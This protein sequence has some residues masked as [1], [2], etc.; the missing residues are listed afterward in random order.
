VS[1]DISD[2]FDDRSRVLQFTDSTSKTLSDFVWGELLT[3]PGSKSQTDSRELFERSSFQNRKDVSFAEVTIPQ[4][5]S[6]H[7]RRMR[8]E[9]QDSASLQRSYRTVPQDSQPPPYYRNDPQDSQPRPYYRN[10]PQDRQPPPYYRNEPRDRQPSH[11][12][13][14]EVQHRDTRVGPGPNGVPGVPPEGYRTLRSGPAPEA[15]KMA[16]S[17][18]GGEYGTMT[19]FDMKGRSYMARVEPHYG[20]TKDN[21]RPHWHKGVTLYEA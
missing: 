19:P 2:M 14:P 20:P 7:Q 16:R 11:N 10:V 9:W 3:I 6:E 15:A 5:A 1:R 8:G 21:P 4:W 12:Y 18:L 17:L 13:R